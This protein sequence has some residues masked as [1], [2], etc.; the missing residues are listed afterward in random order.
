MH[1]V[2]GRDGAT[3]EENWTT[4]VSFVACYTS[5]RDGNRLRCLSAVRCKCITTK[6]TTPMPEGKWS[7][8]GTHCI[9][10]RTLSHTAQTHKKSCTIF[11][12]LMFIFIFFSFCLSHLFTSSYSSCPASF[13][14]STLSEADNNSSSRGIDDLDAMAICAKLNKKLFLR[15]FDG[16]SNAI[17]IARWRFC[18]SRK[19]RDITI[20]DGQG[21]VC[22]P[23][24]RI[25]RTSLDVMLSSEW[26]L[27][28][29]Y[30]YIFG[31][32]ESRVAASMRLHQKLTVSRIRSSRQ[33]A[34]ACGINDWAN[35]F[36]M[37]EWEWKGAHAE[38]CN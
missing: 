11:L 33:W 35:K 26:V 22:R 15:H 9:E 37:A 1:S 34:V 14:C 32:P 27:W 28:A 13:R 19:Q 29:Q 25:D 12:Q 17:N 3:L 16:E 24:R 31:S 8:V 6:M 4:R 23:Y 21:D 30:F 10:H 2:D 38:N 20:V 36:P 5:C 18:V 7:P